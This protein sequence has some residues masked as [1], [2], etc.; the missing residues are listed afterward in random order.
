MTAQI[1][2]AESMIGS[3]ASRSITEIPSTLSQAVALLEGIRAAAQD[4][5]AQERGVVLSRLRS[6]Q[7]KLF[8]FSSAMG[9]SAAILRGYSRRAGESFDEYR[10]G[11][12]AI[13]SRDPA[14]VNLSV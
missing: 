3:A 13:C 8:V 14:F 4:C 7:T 2:S 6:F 5:P 11:G 9:R 1:D 12:S 10:P